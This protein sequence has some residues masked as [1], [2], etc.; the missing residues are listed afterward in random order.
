[1]T[2]DFTKEEIEKVAQAILKNSSS[3]GDVVKL[4]NLIEFKPVYRQDNTV[5]GYDIYKYADEEL[6]AEDEDY[7]FDAD[8]I[9]TVYVGSWQINKS[10]LK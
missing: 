1:M 5:E 9:C 6:M 2:A 3:N 7:D 4:G 10:M 8:Y